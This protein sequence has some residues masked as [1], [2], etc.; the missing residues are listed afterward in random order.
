MSGH[1]KWATIKRDKA[2][3]DSKKS[4]VFTKLTRA[5]TVAAKKGSDPESNSTL[6]LAIDKAKEARMPRDNIERAIQKGSGGGEGAQYEEV[7][8]EGYG[9][10]GVA[11]YIHVLTDN[12]NR[13]VSEIRGLFNRYG[14][15]L[16]SAGS[17]AYIFSDLQNPAFDIEVRDAAKAKSILALAEALEDLDDVSEVFTNVKVPDELLNSL[18]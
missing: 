6:R 17:T 2:A 10:E 8:Y 4:Q 18:C 3:N 15:S 5:I 1:S 14:G 7:I 16:G 13:T 9:P 12:R 11:F